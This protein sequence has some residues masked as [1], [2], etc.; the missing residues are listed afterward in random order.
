MIF[1]LSAL[2]RLQSFE[3]EIED[4]QID[5]LKK[6]FIKFS[7]KTNERFLI[8]RPSHHWPWLSASPIHDHVVRKTSQTSPSWFIFSLNTDC[9]NVFASNVNIT[10]RSRKTESFQQNFAFIKATWIENHDKRKMHKSRSWVIYL[11]RLS[12]W[13]LLRL[14]LANMFQSWF[15]A[16]IFFFLV[17]YAN[18]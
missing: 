18:S 8:K 12:R 6:L 13:K 7:S 14:L 4:E 17:I 2:N 3:L 16:L 5:R 1:C 10:N 9:A 11:Y 15:V